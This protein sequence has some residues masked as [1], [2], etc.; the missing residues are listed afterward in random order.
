MSTPVRIEETGKK[1]NA[2]ASLHTIA[3][4]AHVIPAQ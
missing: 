3:I 1:L 4:A 2:F